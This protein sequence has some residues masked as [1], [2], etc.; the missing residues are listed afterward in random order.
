MSQPAQPAQVDPVDPVTGRTLPQDHAPTGLRRGSAPALRGRVRLARELARVVVPVECS[1]P[2]A[3]RLDRLDGVPPFPVWTLMTYSGV[4]RD[5]VVSWKDRGR[6]DLT[7]PLCAALQRAGADRA[8][9]LARGL[10]AGSTAAGSTAAGSTAAGSTA[11]GSTAA[12]SMAAASMGAAFRTGRTIHVVPVPSSRASRRRRGADLVRLLAAAVVAGLAE[13]GA[14]AA[15]E[16]CL[17]PA[18]GTR[19]QVGLGVRGRQRNRARSVRMRRPLPPGAVVVL[20]DDVLT[21]GATLAACERAVAS[22]G[23]L[24]VG[25]LVLAA[26]PPPGRPGSGWRDT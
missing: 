17:V 10:S 13:G 16:P 6:A 5:L 18:G 8:E 26:T 19:D 24:V 12:D 11:P 1:A 4:V 3:P 23:G 14:P 21:T 2:G 15:L 9:P 25:A 22:G 20:V 7:G